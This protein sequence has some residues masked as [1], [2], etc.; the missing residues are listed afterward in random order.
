MH[1]ANIFLIILI[2]MFFVLLLLLIFSNN[3]ESR[4]TYFHGMITT[5]GVIF[6]IAGS[7]HISM[8]QEQI[9]NKPYLNVN[10]SSILNIQGFENYNINYPNALYTESVGPF[11]RNIIFKD[12]NNTKIN[13]RLDFYLESRYSTNDMYNFDKGHIGEIGYC[14]SFK[15]FGNGIAKNI[16]LYKLPK[17]T[18]EE[19]AYHNIYLEENSNVDPLYNHYSTTFGK[20]DYLTM[21]FNIGYYIKNETDIVEFLIIYNDIMG[22]VYYGVLRFSAKEEWRNNTVKTYFQYL[23]KD[24]INM[25]QEEIVKNKIDIIFKK[26][27]HY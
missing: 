15:N 17:T 25:P 26:V 19:N 18:N 9:N 8:N 11:G 21:H 6:S 2:T 5:I 3:K 22:N 7:F 16:Q 20:D 1:V 27:F 23:D 14:I 13:R 4:K 24:E 12:Y 10:D